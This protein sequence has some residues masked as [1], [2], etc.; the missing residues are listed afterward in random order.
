MNNEIKTNSGAGKKNAGIVNQ[1][2][3]SETKAISIDFDKLVGEEIQKAKNQVID[4]VNYF[5]N[6]LDVLKEKEK[7][8]LEIKKE[9]YPFY[10]FLFIGSPGTG[11]T[12]IANLVGKLMYAKGILPTSKVVE[13]QAGKL[14]SKYV[15]GVNE[16]LFEFAN[17]AEGGVLLI[18]EL[19]AI[20]G[21]HSNG[22]TAEEFM[23]GI[24]NVINEYKGNIC[25]ILCGYEKEVSNILQFDDGADRRFPCKVELK[26][27]SV[28][29]LMLIL[30]KLLEDDEMTL[31]EGVEAVIRN[32]IQR[33]KASQGNRFGNVGFLK[34]KL[35]FKIKIAYYKRRANDGVYTLDDVYAAYPNARQNP[36]QP[37]NIVNNIR[38]RKINRSEIPKLE[39]P[40]GD[41][42]IKNVQTLAKATEPAI[43]YIK[44]DLGTGTAFLISP[45]G[46]AITCNHL[47]KN[48]SEIGVCLKVNGEQEITDFW[49]NCEVINA[50]ETLDIALIK[51]EG[52]NFPYLKLADENR[53][54]QKGEDFILSGYPFGIETKYGITIFKGSITSSNLQR[55]ENGNSRF[56][57]NCEGKCGNSGSP[58]ISCEDGCVIGL[59][60]GSKT[61][62]GD[63]V[64]EEINF[65]RPILYFWENFLK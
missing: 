16:K 42:A 11:K 50:D 4:A 22:N 64:T 24:V 57:I 10:N 23:R 44:T 17:K 8:G 21:G 52:S 56:F 1:N 45:E 2:L 63:N 14:G 13:V 25:V 59:F 27:Y 43:L 41:E 54:I 47:I 32:I 18:D 9:D 51:L 58:I 61:H 3:V 35:L 5:K 65:M 40:Y 60:L 31:G 30:N 15:H 20:N 55:D 19:Q 28:D 62:D 7:N 48:S 29:T 34:D 6:R 46:Y 53:K 38:Y 49:Y 26:S 36:Q 37:G 39:D 12:T 33:E